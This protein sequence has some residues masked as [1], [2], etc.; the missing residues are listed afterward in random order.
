MHT[1]NFKWDV[2][3][4]EPLMRTELWCIEKVNPEIPYDTG[5]PLL[6]LSHKKTELERHR[7]ANVHCSSITIAKTWRQPKS[8]SR[9]E[10]TK[11]NWYMYRW[12]IS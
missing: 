11:K 2:T 6:G 9:G 12:N 10:W 5:G 8:P 4:K 1:L 7:Q 3:W